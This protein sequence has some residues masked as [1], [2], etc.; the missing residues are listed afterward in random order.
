M[1]WTVAL[2][3]ALAVIGSVPAGA[4]EWVPF[5]ES[6]GEAEAVAR[7]ES[8]N[9]TA[10]VIEVEIPGMYVSPAADVARSEVA[11]SVPGAGTMQVPGLPDL[12][13]MSYLVAIPDRGSVTLDFV[14][15]DERVIPGYDVAPAAPFAIQGKEIAPAKRNTEAY[16]RDAFYPSAHAEIGEPVIMRDLR[17]VQ[18]RVYPVR[19]NPATRTLVAVDRVEISL[20]YTDDEGVNEKTTA[21]PY[22]SAAFEPIYESFVLNYDRLPRAQVRR[23]SYLIIAGDAFVTQMA[24][25]VAWKRDRGIE[26]VLVPLSDIG[27]MPSDQDIKDYIQDAYDTWENPPDYVLLVGDT[28]GP[29][30]FL[31][32]WYTYSS[33]SS[34]NVTDHPYEELEGADYFPELLIG[35]M[36]VDTA[37]EVIVASLKVLS[38]ERDC[39][40]ANDDWYE[41]GLMVAGNYGGAHV[42]SPR[43]TTLRV[44]EML[45]DHGYAE[46]DTIF[47]TPVPP[48]PPADAIPNAINAGVGI[49][50]YRGWGNAQGWAYPEFLVDD[51]YALSNG[52]MLPVMT[53]VVCGTGNFDSF[54]VDPAFCEAWIR[55]GTPVDLKGG[56]ACVAPSDYDT[57]TKWNNAVD[58][59]IYRG[60]LT[61]GYEHLGQA[62]L[63]GKMEVLNNFPLH[64][65]P[66]DSFGVEFYFDI[67]NIV[68]DPEL[69]LRTRRPSTL[70]VSHEATIPHGEN[71]VRVRVE[72][73]G[74]EVVPGAEVCVRREGEFQ[75]VRR[76]E[77]GQTI[78][79]P[80][81]ASIPGAVNVT[82]WAEDFKPYT[83][84]VNV[85]QATNFAGYYDHTI[86]DDNSGASSGNGDGIANPGET[87]EVT[88]TLKNYGTAPLTGVECRLDHPQTGQLVTYGDMAP[89][90][91]STGSG[92][93][94]IEAS[95]A[96]RNGGDCDDS[97]ECVD[98]AMYASGDGGD[99]YRSQLRIP[100]VSP[101]L[102][103]FSAVID[104]G[105]DGVL[106]P[107]ETA[108]LAVAISN[109]GGHDAISVT[110]TVI[111][112][113][114]GLTFS[115]EDG[116]WGTIAAGGMESNTTN[117]FTLSADAGVAIGHEFTIAL[118]LEGDALSQSFVFPIVVGTP[119]TDAPQGPDTHGY[120]CYDDTDTDYSEAPTYS[121]IEI[122]PDYGGSGTDLGLGWETNLNTSIPFTFRYYGEDFDEIGVC[123]NGNVGLGGMPVWE[124]QPRNS[125][126][127][128]PLGPDAMIAPFWDDLNP[129]TAGKVLTYDTG[130][131][132]FVVEWSRVATSYEN[133]GA[134]QTF[135]LVLH[136]Q[137]VFPTTSGDGEILYQYHTIANSDTHNYATVGI[138]NPM[139]TDGLLYT[140]YSLYA[141]EAATLAN[142]RAI[143]YT[144]DPPDAFPSTDVA[145]SDAPFGVV[146]ERNR[147]NPFNPVTTISY[148][149]PTAG[150]VEL[151]VYDVAGRRVA[152]V[153]DGEAEAG[154]HEVTWNGRS[155]TG[156]PVASGV[157]FYRLTALGEEHAKK[158]ILMK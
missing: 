43:Q 156:E 122:D 91:T 3:L 22:R 134:T 98:Y 12:P 61:E 52:K 90:A 77:G 119:T 59:G 104:D 103:Y 99:T 111:G 137:D 140:F 154:F 125:T 133:G 64:A 150:R 105:G 19:Y 88:V 26:T 13:V 102:S 139:Q 70:V 113:P 18:V 44:R 35:R 78:V 60:I 23:G 32:P 25:F 48:N 58:A 71:Y 47:W 72:D 87:L 10:T 40:A 1:R 142:G 29:W 34:L 124:H 141:A 145:G 132:R 85:V 153:F 155:G 100:L 16:V 62:M 80:V 83:G 93:F 46:V 15:S 84:T 108:T 114:S 143:K 21:R 117:T 107:G 73:G 6:P 86:D 27:A 74:G 136:D 79:V 45:F 135:Q 24:D 158:M 42:T 106:D 96:G 57:H 39:D 49:I 110:G 146:L 53:S 66:G 41:K 68:G 8:S 28:W 4:R 129:T 131:G 130:D 54:G 69:S 37:T 112:P 76:L 120:Y 82:V 65:A 95:G 109:T 116:A 152:T 7:V 138:E 51:V 157:Y 9:R 101:L 11:I 147:P 97:N 67:Y 144:T 118:N 75:E 127:P 55:A 5:V 20:R 126:I 56:P 14:T 17:L 33:T 2:I 121:W 36:T 30:G 92:P 63:C 38:Y 148:G 123:S 81:D 151:T 115:D 149:L 94:V 128:A 31:P 89:G 50:N